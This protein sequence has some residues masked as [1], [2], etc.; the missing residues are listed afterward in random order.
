MIK[1][2]LLLWLAAGFTTVR[3]D[4]N[5]TATGIPLDSNWK[6]QVYDFAKKNVRHPSWGLAHSERDYQ[7]TKTLASKE[8]LNLDDDVLFATAFLHDIGGIAPFDKKGVDHAVRSVEVV[9]PLLQ[10]WGFPMKKFPL[11]KEM[12]LGHTYY[13]PV[14]A[15]R[16][17]QAFRDADVLDF[18]GSIGIARIL[19]TT[20]EQVGNAG[21]IAPTVGTLKD[22][23]K[24]MAA[25]C[26]LTAC[27]ELAK[28]RQLELEQ[29]L[30]SI[31]QQS[32]AGRAL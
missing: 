10:Q 11:V 32:F 27:K 31:D 25:Q 8:A 21:L 4:Q 23:A 5:Q 28:P 9:E 6:I 19:A 30:F 16:E 24:T 26:S 7:V 29:F 3:A 1:S 12:I 15:S 14:P 22:F 13:G 20:E 17:A 18:L 2:I